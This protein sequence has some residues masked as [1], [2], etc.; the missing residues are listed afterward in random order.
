MHTKKR[1]LVAVLVLIALIL[2]VVA[3]CGGKKNDTPQSAGVVKTS[4]SSV[5]ALP[6]AEREPCTLASSGP[7]A[8]IDPRGQTVIWWHAYNGAHEADLQALIKAFN[9][10]NACGITVV[11]ENQ[12]AA[13]RD[14]MHT[15]FTA[16]EVPGMVV[17]DQYDQA[18]YT[19]AGGLADLNA[20]IA[21]ET[22]GLSPE[23]REDFTGIFLQ[24]DNEPRFG[25]PLTRTVDVLFYNQTWL[26]E[27]RFSDLP[28]DTVT[29]KAMACAAAKVRDAEGYIL[30]DSASA[31]AAWTDAVGDT[32]DGGTILNDD[33]TNY[34]YNN[35]AVVDTVTYLKE[36]YDE[37]CAAFP[38]EESPA[39]QF[40]TRRALFVQGSSADIPAYK[41]AMDGDENAAEG[42][43]G[44]GAESGD[45]W[46]VMPVPHDDAE[47]APTIHGSD[48]MIPTTNPE[49][50]LAAWIFLKWFAAPEQQAGWIHVD[51]EFPVRSSTADALDVKALMPQ[52]GQ[53][54]ALLPD[55]V[56]EP[57]LV[58]Y[59]A[60][61]EAVA[62]A[63]TRIIEGDDVWRTLNRLQSDANNLQKK[64]LAEGILPPKTDLCSPATSG[65]LVDIDPRG[66]TVTW[67][68]TYS[69]AREADLQAMI[70][71][72]NATNPCGITVVSEC[73]RNGRNARLGG[74]RPK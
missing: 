39:V 4:E 40:A 45:E 6:E 65:P 30:R 50:Q 12:G 48:L 38:T 28:T 64:V 51:E 25:F 69:G 13:L 60:V 16:G 35:K 22:W 68:H 7:L 10:N 29:F 47:P 20:Y 57:Q 19:L 73:H 14:K 17:G 21:D 27:L 46:A 56:P 59:P 18:S 26:E 58:S 49:T 54:F 2:P 15:A 72:F 71:A 24:E 31:I 67:W 3:A 70:D 11:A 32:A 74:R 1:N 23:D 52:W 43:A 44:S 53:A 61:R 37:G 62:K 5:D 63:F 9:A 34:S 66:Q 36:L 42:D 8:G 33:R 55:G 41:S